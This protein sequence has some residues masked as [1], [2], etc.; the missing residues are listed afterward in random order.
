MKLKNMNTIKSQTLFDI[1]VKFKV[2]VKLVVEG[3][4]NPTT[5]YPIGMA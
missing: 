2:K 5:T 4:Q 1:S 3:G